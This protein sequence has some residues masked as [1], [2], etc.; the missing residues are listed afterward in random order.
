MQLPAADLTMHNAEHAVRQAVAAAAAGDTALDFSKVGRVDSA[1]VM[2]LLQARR[3]C[4]AGKALRIVGAPPVLQGLVAVY[5]LES[6][7]SSA[8]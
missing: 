5:G 4:P 7:L 6:L 1:A 2:L 8:F 3:A